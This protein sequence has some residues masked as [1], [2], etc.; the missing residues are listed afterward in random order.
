MI[1]ARSLPWP[2]GRWAGRASHR[3]SDA[4]ACGNWRLRPAVR[5]TG[6]LPC[7]RSLKW[8][9][10]SL[11]QTAPLPPSAWTLAN[12]GV[13]RGVAM[14]PRPAWC[15][16]FWQRIGTTA[17]CPPRCTR[18]DACGHRHRPIQLRRPEGVR[19]RRARGRARPDRRAA[20]GLR[21]V[22]GTAVVLG[23][24]PRL[25]QVDRGSI[26]QVGADHR[27]KSGL[28]S[29]TS[30]VPASATELRPARRRCF[31]GRRSR[32]LRSSIYFPWT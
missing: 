8:G 10:M 4:S 30:G 5:L 22:D 29:S 26:A 1:G 2:S 3:S 14:P 23:H 28:S 24:A 11:P 18:M 32:S 16:I 31:V 17:H 25:V 7:L 13:W 27:G 21:G 20:H 12:R 9:F 15:P 6:L 19:L